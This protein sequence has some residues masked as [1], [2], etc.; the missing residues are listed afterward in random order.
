M[1][2]KLQVFLFLFVSV[3]FTFCKKPFILISHNSKPF[4]HIPH[5]S[6]P[7]IILI[8]EDDVGYEVPT[9]NGGQAYSTPNMD[10]LS[11]NGIRFTQCHSDSLCSPSRVELLT[12]KFN[13]RNYT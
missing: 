6:K 1:F 7:N 13:F 11:A 2:R 4:I 5:N 3:Y 8:L 12:G 10:M 9:C